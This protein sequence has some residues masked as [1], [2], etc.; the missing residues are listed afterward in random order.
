MSRPLHRGKTFTSDN[1]VESKALMRTDTPQPIK[2]ANY[3]PYP[4]TIET[5]DLNFILDP[6]ATLVRS[7]L[8]VRRSD[9]GSDASNAPL[10]LHGENI[11]LVG[12]KLDGAVLGEES[13]VLDEGFLRVSGLP[14]AFILE[15]ET[16]FSPKKNLAL[17][18]LYMSAGRY[19]TQ[20]EAEG[21]RR[22]TFYPDRPDVMSRFT[23]RIEAPIAGFPTL[24]SNGNLI[25]SG[26]LD[27]ERHFACWEDP[28]PKPAYLFALVAGGFDMLEDSFTTMSAREIALR[29]Y[30]DPG[31][32]P[33]AVFAMDALKRAMKWDEE[34]FG[35]EY[36]LDLFMIVAVRDFNFGA[37]ENKGLN[38][39][40]SSALL[41]DAQTATDTNFERI[42]S[43]VAHE[44]FHNWTGNRITCRD[45][46]QLCLK[47]GLTVYRDQE[48][49]ADMRGAAI[50]RIKD[51][52]SL[53]AR[54]F[55]EDAGP[56][57]HP[58][59]PEE[60]VKI[61]NFY[62]ATIYE[63]G[64]ELIRMLK[65]LIGED[66]FAKGM[67]R[68]FETL[69]GTA[70]TME[71]FLLT[72]EAA[73]GVD[74]SEFQHWY[75][76]AGT[77]CLSA[78]EDWDPTTGT[79]TLTL[80][81][82][83]APTP[84]QADKQ[85]LPIPVRMGLLGKDGPVPITMLGEGVRGPLERVIILNDAQQSWFLTG[86]KERPLV[87]LLRGFSA[88]V[89]LKQS[90]KPEERARLMTA[91][92]DLFSRWEEAQAYGLENI[93]DLTKKLIAN[94]DAHVEPAYLDALGAMVENPDIDPAFAALGIMPPSEHDIFQ[95][96]KPADPG[97]IRKARE[98]VL[99]TFA[100]RHRHT[101]LEALARTHSDAPFSPDAADAGRRAL[102]GAVLGVLAR[103]DAEEGG[104]L[105]AKAFAK[106]D[107]M[108]DSLAAL[109]ALDRSGSTEFET[110]LEVFFE[111]WEDN[112]M[113]L[114][115]WFAVQ[116]GSVRDDAIA[117]TQKLL[118][119]PLY[120]HDNPNRVRSV[121]GVFSQ[122]NQ[123]AFHA[124]SGQGYALLAEEIARIDPVNPALAARLLGA[125][126]AWRQLEPQRGALAKA[127]VSGILQRPGLSANSYEIASRQLG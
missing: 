67:D 55:P 57:A 111:R 50:A 105:A 91:D 2:L 75:A 103:L 10:V 80:R 62:T 120:T 19:T 44:Y 38:I 90:R 37:M 94:E 86:L 3:A 26:A 46:F 81:Q 117:R 41:A 78:S 110:A 24:L 124:L 77:P 6:E 74:L 122:G 121:I 65:V 28:F 102:H 72:F 13:Y 49:S 88:P 106:A 66:G 68:Y 63:K 51:V 52:I 39:F 1:S 126:E 98:L 69:D 43:I 30:A 7:T 114:D 23:T 101:L 53:R 85:A 127:A 12:L 29:I 79:L 70:A 48:F 8:K 54:Q 83:T 35:R 89:N 27:G 119:H 113:V 118:S 71:Q 18:G 116:A 99:S 115:K 76:Q 73:A 21:F 36:D 5:V 40:N 20:C 32:A 82:Q 87:S 96:M 100:A 45:W 112:P 58:V 95:H 15:I 9:A 93:I 92:P 11:E 108:T 123:A 107:N 84:G 60:Y 31:D 22:I 42:E 61:D 16:R 125:F 4:F 33:R 64:A 97:H 59:R 34:V 25:E 104:A 109:I 17:S 56:L 14:T 47:E